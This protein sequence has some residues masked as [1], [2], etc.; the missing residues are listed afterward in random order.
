M[1]VGTPGAE[2]GANP[3]TQGVS[4]SMPPGPRI[5]LSRGSLKDYAVGT[6]RLY[7]LSVSTFCKS[8]TSQGTFPPVAV[9]FLEVRYL[10]LCLGVHRALQFTCQS[11]SVSS[12]KL[13]NDSVGWF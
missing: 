13:H 7:C 1:Y 8:L 12:D 5:S 11:I 4:P 10:F 2:S 6:C 9:T 3:E